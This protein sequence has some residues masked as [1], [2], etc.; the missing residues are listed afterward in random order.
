MATLGWLSGFTN[1]LCHL[2]ALEVSRFTFNSLR[3]TEAAQLMVNHTPSPPPSS[4]T[5][6]FLSH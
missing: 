5:I 1:V 2:E 4:I 6:T 3:S